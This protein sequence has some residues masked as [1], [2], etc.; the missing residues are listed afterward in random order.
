MQR[1]KVSLLLNPERPRDFMDDA[2]F[3]ITLRT[4]TTDQMNPGIEVVV[5]TPEAVRISARSIVSLY[6]QHGLTCL[7]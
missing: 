7:S 3:T 2:T 4:A 6:H 1:D 5:T